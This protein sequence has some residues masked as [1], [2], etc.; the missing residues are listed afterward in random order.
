M[1]NKVDY[2]KKI[3][4]FNSDKDIIALKEKYK[5][6]TFFEIISKQR[7]E[8]TY[9]SFLKWMFQLSCIDQGAVS[10]ILLLLD[11][12]VVKS[13]NMQIPE[14]LKTHIITRNFRFKNIE[15]ETEKPVSSVA[16]DLGINNNN[17]LYKW[18]EE[19]AIQK[20]IAKCQDRIDIFINCD[21]E[22]NDKD[23]PAKRLQ[24]VIE[25]KI[26]SG[27]GKRK[28]KER[29]GVEGY[30]DASQTA[31][32]YRATAL[33][34][35]DDVIQLYVYLAPAGAQSCDLSDVYVQ[36][37][38]QDIVD[39]IILPMLAS[40]SLSVRQRF[41]LEELKTELTFPSLESTKVRNSIANSSECQDIFSELWDN[42]GFKS[43]ILDA[44]INATKT[45]V[46]CLNDTY[47][48]NRVQVNE[49]LKLCMSV[50]PDRTLSQWGMLVDE[51]KSGKSVRLKSKRREGLEAFAKELGIKLSKV[52]PTGRDDELLE[53][54]WNNNQKFLLAIMSGVK[55][56]VTEKDVIEHLL[57][58]ST[59]RDTTKYRVYYKGEQLNITPAN[60]SE[61]AWIIISAYVK[62]EKDNNISLEEL[63]NLFSTDACNSYYSNGKW[64]KHLFYYYSD[65]GEYIADGNESEGTPVSAGGWDFYAPKNSND[66]K[67]QINP[68]NGKKIIMLKMWRKGD[69]LKL[70]DYVKNSL[71]IELEVKPA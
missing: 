68:C 16:A 58:D 35:S 47:R 43:L 39:G 10:P 55:D 61:A 66:S 67:F 57:H 28:S 53:A 29:I 63:N 30:D 18:E 41:F 49:I 46:W 26:D 50:N 17:S 54:F 62:N 45:D 60:N 12:L 14:N 7:S 52:A 36:I 51:M 15:V 64:L 48:V 24:I 2:R 42:K 40:S 33:D 20:I 27:E 37:D 32:Y 5:E 11:V 65:K 19:C 44:A 22:L 34:T 21:I 70:V 31:R 25:N 38:Y 56:I 69:L 3:I 13:A 23:T 59:K 71:R 1:C 8:T 4:D 6:P 9:S